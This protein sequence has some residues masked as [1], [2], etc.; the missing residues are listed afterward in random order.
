MHK[1]KSA[2]RIEW[3]WEYLRKKENEL[4]QNSATEVQKTNLVEMHTHYQ[5]PNKGALTDLDHMET[6]MS[7]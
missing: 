6:S 2:L 5:Q 7:I 1:M 4:F 3:P